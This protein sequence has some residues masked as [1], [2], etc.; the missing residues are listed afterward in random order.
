MTTNTPLKS[1]VGPLLA[2]YTQNARDLP[3][4]QN[5][6]PY[7]VF[8]SEIMLQQT[9]VEAAI[10]HYLRFLA[11]LPG[12]ASLAAVPEDRLLKLWEGLGYYNRARNLQKAAQAVMEQYGGQLPASYEKLLTLPGVGPYTAAAVASIAFGIP[13]PAVDGN[14]LRVLSRLRADSADIAGQKTKRDAERLLAPII[15]AHAAGD[16]TQ[17]MMELGAVIC[18]P[19]GAPLCGQCPLAQL[20]E[21]FKQQRQ[22]QFPVKSPK[23]ARR[24]ENRTIL[25]ITCNGKV[26]L[27]KRNKTGLLA[28]MWEYPSLDGH[29]TEPE[30]RAALERL[31]VAVH[32]VTPL[33]QTFKHIFTHVEWHMTG[34]RVQ[35]DCQAGSFTW[36]AQTDLRDTHA[37]PSA[38]RGFTNLLDLA[39]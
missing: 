17:A 32:A 29:T 7:G 37:L 39:D 24:K 34:Y 14:V 23:K 10:G 16:F 31:G 21:A 25:L 8:L 5:P 18:L 20:C 38:F 1:I 28:G 6:T 19:N 27:Q 9:R 11:E 36:A 33:P 30:I 4:R 12:F 13:A 15:P 2:W 35:A 3:W 22:A 26:A